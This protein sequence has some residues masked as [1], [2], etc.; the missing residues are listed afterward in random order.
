[1]SS[2]GYLIVLHEIQSQVLL[3]YLI[4]KLTVSQISSR[5]GLK[6]KTVSRFLERSQR[7]MNLLLN[8]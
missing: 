3:L 2:F 1:M 7:E 4:E 6:E 8:K 5:L